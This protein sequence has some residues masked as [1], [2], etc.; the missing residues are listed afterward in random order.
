MF[1]ISLSCPRLSGWTR[2]TAG[3]RNSQLIAFEENQRSRI[4]NFRLR[5][6]RESVQH[7]PFWMAEMLFENPFY[8]RDGVRT[9]KILLLAHTTTNGKTVFGLAWPSPA[10][11]RYSVSLPVRGAFVDPLPSLG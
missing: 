11:S 4:G 8:P 3:N 1:P 10:S 2:T 5:Q 9:H 6:L 7:I